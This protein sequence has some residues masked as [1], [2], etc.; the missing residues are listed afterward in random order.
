VLQLLPLHP[1]FHPTA[2]ECGLELGPNRAA[3]LD[4]EELL[5]SHFNASN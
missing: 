5:V 3:S 4:A 1:K 2:H